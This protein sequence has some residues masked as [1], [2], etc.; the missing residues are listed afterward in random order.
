[1]RYRVFPIPSI[2][3]AALSVVLFAGSLAAQE[4]VH[5]RLSFPAPQHHY[6]QVEVTFSGVASP[7]LEVRMS[8]SSPGRYAVHE[9]AKN[10]FDLHA[11]DGAG[12]E[13]RPTRPNPYQWDIQGH[14]GSVRIVYKIFGNHVD[15]TYLAID[16]SHAHMNM[17]AT[18]MW[19]RGFD[20][21]PVRITF[22]P[23]AAGNWKPATQLFPTDDEWTFTAPN[24][25][26]LMDSPTELSNQAIRSFKVRNPDGR[27]YTIRTA[28][29]HDG[30]ASAVDAYAEGVEKIVNE[31]A[32]VFGEFPSY[33]T[34]TYTFLGD[35]VPWGGGDGMEHRNSTVVASATSFK[36]LDAVRSALGTVSHEFFHGWNVERIRPRTLEPFNFEEANV[37]G[38]L[39]L[40]EG[41][42]QYYGQLV[43]ARAGLMPGEQG[44]GLVRSALEIINAPGRQFHSPVEMSQMAPFTDAAAAI[45]ETNFSNTFISYYTYGAAL[46]A[47]LDFSLRDRSNSRITLDDFMR[48]MW[49]AYGK[50]DGP[51]P[52]IVAKPYT[53]QDVRDRL[54]D[55][56]GDR[57]FANEF[58][59]R[60]IEGREVPDYARLFA[61]AGLVLRKRN[62]NAPW[63][64]V[65]DEGGPS[66]PRRWRRVGG[67][68]AAVGSADVVR[69]PA[70][71]AWGTPAFKAGLEE[72]DVVTAVDGRAIGGI[73]DWYAALAAHK[74]GDTMAV[75][76]T[77]Q[78]S[79]AT[80]SL[81][82]GEDPALEVVTLE[83]TGAALTPEQKAFRAAWLGSRRK[84]R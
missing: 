25:Q 23:P 62:P 11:F 78:G 63:V 76:Y 65:L 33:D 64:G 53:L 56:A 27:E 57:A 10:V 35:Y 77:R 67:Q 59:D 50:P 54:A 30:D 38:E 81:M 18:L 45:D 82:V 37:S 31:A 43:M 61:R 52:A 4:P 7:T 22:Q 75:T 29:H 28:V 34:G 12:R 51:S 21:R 46:A 80:T 58:F 26:Y 17:P 1:M 16:A 20:L 24:L 13:L 6:A 2:A 83:S 15:G 14:N 42:T 8:R 44:A 72:S 41:F 9:F 3:A 5:Y 47:A 73:G 39:W 36:N 32:A 49:T 71:V 48:A 60:Y 68:A 69:I 66:A 84:A 70:L 40:A 55:V 79:T 74:P 19:A